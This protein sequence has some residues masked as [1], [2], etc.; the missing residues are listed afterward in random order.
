MFQAID[1]LVALFRSLVTPDVYVYDGP[2]TGDAGERIQI[3]VAYSDSEGGPSVNGDAGTSNFGFPVESY[4]IDCSIS[5]SDGDTDLASK[6]TEARSLFNSLVGAVRA[7][8]SLGGLIKLPG[9]AEI[10]GFVYV[11]DQ[12]E[13]GS[14][15]IA[16]F[17][18]NC[19]SVVIWGG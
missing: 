13:T 6:R 19:N 1:Y 14:V 11:Q 2:P 12:D 4:E 5:I 10:S 3:S 17:T 15:T 16:A 7:D 8:R 18:V 9:L